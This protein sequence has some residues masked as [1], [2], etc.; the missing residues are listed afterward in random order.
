MDGIDTKILKL[1]EENGRLS[2]EEIGRLLHISR[3][4]I[5]Q[6]VNKLEKQGVIKGYK[7]VIDWGKLGQV[8]KVQIYMKFVS[9]DFYQT[10]RRVMEIDIP[11]VN[12]EDYY[13]L[14]GEWC[15]MLKVRATTPN[16]VTKFIDELRKISDIKETSTTFILSAIM[17]NGFIEINEE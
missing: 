13:R 7:G 1:L 3:P 11:N 16:D 4:A 14:A 8:I 9:P 6:R 2:H 12:I 15:M 10:A 5:H 17:E